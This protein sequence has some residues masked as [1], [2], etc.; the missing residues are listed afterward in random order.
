MGGG[1]F[2]RQSK[3]ISTT[4]QHRHTQAAKVPLCLAQPSGLTA[5]ITR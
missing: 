2:L 4:K 1:E 3:N 5:R